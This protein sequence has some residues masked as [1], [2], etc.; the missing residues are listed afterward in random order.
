MNLL[1]VFFPC[2][3]ILSLTACSSLPVKP[4]Y[5]SPAQYQSF[6]CMQ[7]QAEYNRIQQYLV[8]GVETPK[9][10]GMG[11]GLGLGGGWGRGGWGF[12]PSIS[13]NLGQSSNTKRTEVSQLLGQQ[14]AI[15]QA[16]KF[17][18]CPMQIVKR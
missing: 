12:G 16:A 6:N 14:D 5:V 18:S 17:K 11:V 3:S 9:R 7:L 8:Q 13:F 4:T 15:S 1:K 10:T 2:F